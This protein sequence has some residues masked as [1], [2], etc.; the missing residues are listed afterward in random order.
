MSGEGRLIMKNRLLKIIAVSFFCMS[1]CSWTCV[2]G[3]DLQKAFSLFKAKLINFAEQLKIEQL[4]IDQLKA[5]QQ[6]AEQQKAEQ[7]KAEQQK[8]EKQKAELPFVSTDKLGLNFR[9]VLNGSGTFN[10]KNITYV[11]Y[12]VDTPVKQNGYSAVNIWKSYGAKQYFGKCGCGLHAM[13]NLIFMTKILDAKTDEERNKA[14]Q[15]MNSH[16]VFLDYLEGSKAA[17]DVGGAKNWLSIWGAGKSGSFHCPTFDNPPARYE[18]AINLR[19][20]I[21]NGIAFAPTGSKEILK[22]AVILGDI[23]KVS[24][25]SG[26]WSNGI[27]ELKKRMSEKS[28]FIIPIHIYYTW[29]D[30]SY[31]V[32]HWIAIVLRGLKNNNLEIF[33]IE[34]GISGLGLKK[35]KQLVGYI[36]YGLGIKGSFMVQRPSPIRNNSNPCLTLNRPQHCKKIMYPHALNSPNQNIA[37]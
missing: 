3:D 37:F 28:C 13:K 6:K 36:L 31:P 18:D 32:R 20:A 4:K 12:D 26:V 29:Y 9:S 1:C 19:D 8:I 11:I 24:N 5:E 22:R 23:E 35:H 7:Q 34:S 16:K 27:D 21:F 2:A 10:G 17:G 25:N 30:G 14:I 33:F 15:S